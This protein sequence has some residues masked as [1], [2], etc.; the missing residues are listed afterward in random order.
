MYPTIDSIIY[1]QNDIFAKGVFWAI[2]I[3]GT[4]Y[5]AFKALSVIESRAKV[6]GSIASSSIFGLAKDLV[7]TPDFVV[8][9]PT[10]YIVWSSYNG[11][12]TL[13][14]SKTIVAVGDIRD[15][16]FSNVSFD[17][18][19]EEYLDGSHSFGRN[20]FYRVGGNTTK[21][22][23]DFIVCDLLTYG[24]VTGYA[25]LF[26]DMKAKREAFVQTEKELE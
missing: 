2:I 6:V 22:T 23:P 9:T 18:L 16:E 12:H 24:E 11:R 5:A 10:R 20:H 13:P 17:L 14:R 4:L 19:W 15:G 8:E 3:G 21:D 25:I 7:K 1:W 26:R